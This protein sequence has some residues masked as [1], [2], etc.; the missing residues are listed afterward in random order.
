MQEEG[1][2]ERKEVGRGLYQAFVGALDALKLALDA[3]GAH[4]TRAQ[5]VLQNARALDAGHRTLAKRS[6]LQGTHQRTIGRTTLDALRVLCAGLV[7]AV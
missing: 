7:C 1:N 2:Q 5:R 3:S 4:Q 6:V